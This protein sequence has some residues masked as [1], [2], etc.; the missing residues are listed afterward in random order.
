MNESVSEKEKLLM[1][2]TEINDQLGDVG[3]VLESSFSD[4]RNNWRREELERVAVPNQRITHLENKL[5]KINS[6]E[7]NEFSNSPLA[8]QTA[9]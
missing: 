8:N 2:L 3:S 7:R 1:M 5:E 6:F 9:S 4:L